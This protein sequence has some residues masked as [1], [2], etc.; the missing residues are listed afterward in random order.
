MIGFL[1]YVLE[2]AA[3][4]SHGH[5]GEVKEILKKFGDDLFGE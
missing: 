3:N 4:I 2:R 1:D 5:L